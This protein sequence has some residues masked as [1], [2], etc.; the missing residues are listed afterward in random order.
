MADMD[1]WTIISRVIL[2]EILPPF[3]FFGYSM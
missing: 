1:G 2:I 3:I